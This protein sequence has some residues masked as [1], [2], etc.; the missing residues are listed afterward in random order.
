MKAAVLE[1]GVPFN[2]AHGMHAFE[3]PEIDPRFN[4]VFN[5]A[6]YNHTTILMKKMLE[7]YAGFEDLSEV[8]DVGGGIGTTIGIITKKYPKIKGTNFDLPHV[9]AHA[10][11]YPGT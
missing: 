1:G 8:V 5:T 11:A 4:K 6:M 7:S 10:P 2:K 9:I 3:Y